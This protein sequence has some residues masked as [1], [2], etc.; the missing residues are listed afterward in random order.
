MHLLLTVKSLFLRP[1][2]LLLIGLT[3]DAPFVNGQK[4]I[5]GAK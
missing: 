3:K 1:N 5:F 2:E 4:L